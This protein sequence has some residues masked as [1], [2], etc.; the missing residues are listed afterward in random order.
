ML[1]G[2]P[3]PPPKKG[4]QPQ[5]FGPCLIVYYGQTAVCIRIPLGTEVGLSL[6]DIALDGDPTPPPL[7]G[8]SP[9]IFGSHVR[10][11]Q[12]AGWTKLPLGTEVDLGAGH[13][14]LHE[15]PAPP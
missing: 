6:D 7:K 3:A 13:I 12:T 14:V 8:H 4:A 5:I 1:D 9:P 10:C 15:N 11:G 2:Y